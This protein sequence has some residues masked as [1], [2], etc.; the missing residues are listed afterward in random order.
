MG[1]ANE[2][3]PCDATP[4]RKTLPTAERLLAAR[5]RMPGS[6]ERS[7]VSDI[8]QSA[9]CG[10]SRASRS[11]GFFV[12]S[13]QHGSLRTSRRKPERET[14]IPGL[15]PER[16]VPRSAGPAG[17]NEARSR[18]PMAERTP[19]GSSWRR[20]FQ[21]RA[22]ICLS[23]GLPHLAAQPNAGG[24]DFGYFAHKERAGSNPAFDARTGMRPGEGP[25]AARRSL[26]SARSE[27]VLSSLTPISP[28]PRRATRCRCVASARRW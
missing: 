4:L 24:E 18:T 25:H 27:A 9:F 28:V 5:R 2:H 1:F 19:R 22:K 11:G 16:R 21:R 13:E 17:G 26:A 3:E 20:T 23:S 10:P 6:W 12:F 8:V 15:A 7:R 14:R